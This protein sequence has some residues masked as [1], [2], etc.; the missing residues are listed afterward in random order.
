MASRARPLGMPATI[1]NDRAERKVPSPR[2]ESDWDRGP[3]YSRLCQPSTMR[4]GA[5]DKFAMGRRCW[6]SEVD[7]CQEIRR[8]SD[9]TGIGNFEPP[10]DAISGPLLYQ[11]TEISGDASPKLATIDKIIPIL[12]LRRNGRSWQAAQ[13]T[14]VVE[15]SCN[16]SSGNRR[17]TEG[18]R[19]SFVVR[20]SM[21]SI[22]TIP[23]YHAM[24]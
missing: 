11:S 18:R 21:P 12:L 6:A 20:L 14:R 24:L 19:E 13:P 7:R 4:P 17:E 5:E 3:P 10:R 16:S 15:N 1:L 8:Q 2:K 22:S 23:R 9:R